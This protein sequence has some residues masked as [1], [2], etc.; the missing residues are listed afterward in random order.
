A[1][2]ADEE[3]IPLGLAGEDRVILE[4]ETGLLPVGVLEESPRGHGAGEAAARDHQVEGLTGRRRARDPPLVERVPDPV[5]RVH[6]LRRVPV[7][8]GVVTDAAVAGP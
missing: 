1:L 5:A 2:A 8:A 6:Y 3:F 7:E 4:D